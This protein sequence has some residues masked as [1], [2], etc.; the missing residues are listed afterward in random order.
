M[1]SNLF[2]RISPA[3]SA[4]PGTAT[5]VTSVDLNPSV[6]FILGMDAMQDFPNFSDE[7]LGCFHLHLQQPGELMH[8]YAVGSRDEDDHAH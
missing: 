4:L 3:Q 5:K 2:W 7:C 8:G 6:Q 1:R